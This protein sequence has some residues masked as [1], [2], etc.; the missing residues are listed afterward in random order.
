MSHRRRSLSA[1]FIAY[2]II[3]SYWRLHLLSKIFGKA[4][5]T[6]RINDLHEKN[7]L[8]LKNGIVRLGG[9]FIKVG[10]LFSILSNFL[11]E[12]FKKPLESLQNQLPAKSFSQIE[13][14]I[15]KEL[16]QNI[17][18]IFTDFNQSPIGTASI[19][20][21][22][23]A[24]LLNGSSVVVKVQ[25]AD[26]QETAQVDLA[27]IKNLVKQ[28]SWFFSIKGLDY[29]YQQVQIM[30]EEELDYLHE[31]KA[32]I[33]IADNLRKDQSVVIPKVFEP[34]ST[35][36]VLTT[37]YFEGVK[38]TNHQKLDEWNIDKKI[39]AE[40][41]VTI[42]CKM[43]F[44]DDIYHA[45]P[46]P[47][48]ILVNHEGTICILDFGAVARLSPSIQTELPKLIIAITKQDTA[49]TVDAL[50]EMEFINPGQDA[51]EFAHKIIQIGQDFLH[52][53]IK[54][55]K[56][57]LEGIS[58]DPNSKAFSNLL[59]QLNLK[60]LAASIQIPK[61]SILLQRAILLILG[62]A[63]QLSPEMNPVDVVKP[64]LKKMVLSKSGGW[65]KIIFDSIKS[66]VGTLVSLP[67]A[68]KQ[69][70]DLAQKGQLQVNNPNEIKALEKIN[71]SIRLLAFT[72]L[73]IGA[74]TLSYLYQEQDF[75]SYFM[76]GGILFLA[77]VLKKV[78]KN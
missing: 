61:D 63:N 41:L 22:H 64:Y 65:R 6:N 28:A 18:E 11:P 59:K 3:L 39:L 73:S 21:T 20:Q 29:L 24:K 49:S 72:F 58:V 19:G 26:I 68:I 8:R 12:A 57:N 10:Q 25:H 15:K 17:A 78:I 40:K 45:D 23:K 54:I 38:I 30:I 5:Y 77:L 32:S 2:R 51:S 42:Y 71:H 36:K 76:W 55:D 52:N 62:T 44:E 34:Y 70:L 66:Q 37:S 46:H 35:S 33:L 31:A 53:E 14:T 69:T 75:K 74:F 47:G 43:L 1:N 56:F 27:I 16:G 67:S 50:R 9:L 7:A 48:N 13:A 4:Y 60:E